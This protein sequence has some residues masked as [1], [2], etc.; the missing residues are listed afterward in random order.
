MIARHKSGD[1]ELDDGISDSTFENRAPE[2]NI[3][4][5]NDSDWEDEEDIGL[6]V[7]PP[8]E[9]GFFNSHHGGEAL[10]SSLVDDMTSR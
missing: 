9:E 3:A 6:S 4:D 10:I 8:G 7:L 2:P 1:S 5:G